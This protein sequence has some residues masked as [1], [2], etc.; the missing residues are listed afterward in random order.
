MYEKNG[1]SRDTLYDLAHCFY[2]KA[3]AGYDFASVERKIASALAS[4]RNAKVSFSRLIKMLK[5]DNPAYY[6]KNILPSYNERKEE[7]EQE[8][9]F[10]N[11]P[12]S[13][14]RSPLIPREIT[15]DSKLGDI[16]QQLTVS[17]NECILF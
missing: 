5:E 4:K 9:C 16:T 15:E 12:L 8:I 6:K 7:F 17:R 13:F 3:G 10:I 1:W 14:Y 11:N 2:K